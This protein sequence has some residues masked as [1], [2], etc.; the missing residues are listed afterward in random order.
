VEVFAEAERR[1]FSSALLVL[2]ERGLTEVGVNPQNGPASR[3]EPGHRSVGHSTLRAASSPAPASVS[4]AFRPAQAKPEKV[5]KCELRNPAV[6]S[7]KCGL[8]LGHAG[9]HV[10]A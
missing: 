10:F 7:Q 1:S 2:V 8:E 3:E 4:P 6:P 5:V 9:D